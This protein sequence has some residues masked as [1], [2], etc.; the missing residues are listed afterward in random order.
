MKLNQFP[1]KQVSR[2]STG[3]KAMKLKLNGRDGFKAMVR[4]DGFLVNPTARS[5]LI[6][7]PFILFSPFTPP[8]FIFLPVPPHAAGTTKRA[9]EIPR[10]RGQKRRSTV[11]PAQPIYIY[12]YTAPA[13]LT[14]LNTPIPPPPPPKEGPGLGQKTK[15]H[16]HK[17]KQL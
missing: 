3:T 1:R 9:V 11:Q 8:P 10:R 7:E 6:L 13:H 2:K 15:T 17:K 4:K 5:A 14:S 16:T 12:I